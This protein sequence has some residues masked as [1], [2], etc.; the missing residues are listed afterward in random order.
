MHVLVIGAGTMG[1]GI[2][3]SFAAK[4]YTSYL[5][6]L[7]KKAS[8]KALANII[9]FLDRQIERQRIDEVAKEEL[10]KHLVLLDDLK[11]CGPVDLVI[12]AVAEKIDIKKSL[13]AGLSDLDLGQPIYASNTSS[14]SITELAASSPD[15]AAFIGMHFFNPAPVMKLVELIK[16][17]RTS[18][19]TLAK[20]QTIVEKLDKT[21][22]VVEESPGFVVNR[23]LIPM[24]NE[25]IALLAEGV[26][27]AEDIDTAMQLGANHP[28]GPLALADF[29]GLDIV[30]D[31]LQILHGETLD[32]KY[33]PHLLLKKMV[34]SGKLGRKTKQGFFDYNRN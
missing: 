25:G 18:A 10:L 34:R 24:I 4:G 13:F 19:E 27:T 16:G 20:A 30:L 8:E 14:L 2:A 6:D 11:D 22:V 15:P 21:A 28:M 9:R 3:Q 26:A 7:N 12:E 33:R 31:I 23:L 29:I 1:S 17:E 32:P 5:Y